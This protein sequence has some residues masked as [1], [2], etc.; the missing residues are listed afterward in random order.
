M[1]DEHMSPR[2]SRPDSAMSLL[3]IRVTPGDAGPV[4]MTLDDDLRITSRTAA[5]QAWL[6]V[7]LPPEPAE[8]GTDHKEKRPDLEQVPG[9][10]KP[11]RTR[12]P[13]RPRSARVAA[14]R[15]RGRRSGSSNGARR[16]SAAGRGCG[17]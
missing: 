16:C 13:V 6:D 17:R 14:S 1:H 8:Q 3:D 2:P 11:A 7:L 10:Q 5:S 4:V 9:D 12:L 15:A